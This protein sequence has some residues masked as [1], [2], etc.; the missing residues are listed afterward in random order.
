MD[1]IPL[2]CELPP[3]DPKN[4]VALLLRALEALIV[5]A[6]P[7]AVVLGLVIGVLGLVVGPRHRPHGGF[8]ESKVDVARVVVTKYANEAFPQWA[9][10]HPSRDCPTSLRELD[11]YMDKAK[12]LDPWGRSYAFT[13]GQGRLYVMSLGRDG[14]SNT[15]DDLWSHQ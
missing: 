14:R 11:P 15:A 7:I 9:R 2:A 3:P 6:L 13:C 10:T 1:L 8:A 12:G 5:V 4:L